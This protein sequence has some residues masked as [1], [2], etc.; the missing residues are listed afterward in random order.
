MGTTFSKTRNY[1]ESTL[2]VGISDT[3][4]SFA[5]ASGGGQWPDGRQILRITD[6]TK[7][8]LILVTSRSGV[9]FTVATG[10]RGVGGTAAITWSSGAIVE[11]VMT[12]DHLDELQ[13][14]VNQLE[15]WMG[16]EPGGVY[17]PIYCRSSLTS[18]NVAANT[19]YAIPYPIMGSPS[20]SGIVLGITQAG[21]AG[22]LFRV[23][24][25]QYSG[26]GETWNLLGESEGPCDAVAD[27]TALFPSALETRPGLYLLVFVQNSPAAVNIRAQANTN[28][29]VFGWMPRSSLLGI[30]THWTTP[31]TY[32][33]LPSTLTLSSMA[34]TGATMPIFALSIA[35]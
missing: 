2:A 17:L 29:T 19:I 20:V 6:G 22:S 33:P 3:A 11:M 35:V 30:R 8:E 32:N 4:T 15:N 21:S 9:T 16:Y 12:A 24:L 34:S 31:H 27:L 23:G 5:V 14:A 7:N 25:Y 28:S 10:G 13:G 26:S 1:L 18:I